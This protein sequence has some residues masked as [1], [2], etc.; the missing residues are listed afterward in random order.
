MLRCKNENKQEAQLMLTNPCDAFSG[1]SKSPNI[2]MLGTVSSCAIVTLSFRGTV[3][4]IFD[5]KN[6]CDFEIGV[7]GHS[8]SLKVAPFERLCMVS[9]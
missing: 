3:F 1:Q 8:R 2:H 6:F 7:R 5:F 4:M 9:Y